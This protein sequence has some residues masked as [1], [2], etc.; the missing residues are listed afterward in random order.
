MHNKFKKPVLLPQSYAVSPAQVWAIP[1]QAWFAM[2]F[3]VGIR[4]SARLA[5][6]MLWLGLNVLFHFVGP[7]EFSFSFSKGTDDASA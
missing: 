1:Y 4:V 5:S 7:M 2:V 6:L 3:W